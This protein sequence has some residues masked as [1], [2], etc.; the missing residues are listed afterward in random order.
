MSEK[1]QAIYRA[2]RERDPGIEARRGMVRG[3]QLNW[4]MIEISGRRLR[5]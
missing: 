5:L 4:S 2:L 3:W 1:L